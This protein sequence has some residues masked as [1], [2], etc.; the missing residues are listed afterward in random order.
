M[1]IPDTSIWIEFLKGNKFFF[2]RLKELLEKNKVLAI[3]CI[4]GELLQGTR[5]KREQRIVETYWKNLPQCSYGDVWIEAGKLSSDNRLY[6]KGI[7]I[8]DCVIILSGRKS[9]AKIWSLDKK[10][11]SLLKKDEQFRL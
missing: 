2:P 8:I 4:F 6:S 3:E 5:S 1:I 10:L 11:N 7:G 9:G